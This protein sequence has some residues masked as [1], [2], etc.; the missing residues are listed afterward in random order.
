MLWAEKPRCVV[1]QNSIR[2][3]IYSGIARFSLRWH[4]CCCFSD[5]RLCSS[6]ISH[7]GCS[8]GASRCGLYT[9]ASYMIDKM[10]HDQEVDV[11]LSCRYVIAG[12]PTAITSQV[13][14]FKHQQ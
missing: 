2:I 4:G 14:G 3:E 1:M 8:D 13:S 9:A 12:R 11:L 5:G 7:V 6:Y 10:Q